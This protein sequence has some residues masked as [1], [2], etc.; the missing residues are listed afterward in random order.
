[1]VLHFMEAQLLKISP[2]CSGTVLPVTLPRAAGGRVHSEPI[3][4]LVFD[5]GKEL[6]VSD[7]VVSPISGRQAL[8]GLNQPGF[9]PFPLCSDYAVPRSPSQDYVIPRKMPSASTRASHQRETNYYPTP[10]L[11]DGVP[12]VI[13]ES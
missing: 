2:V 11:Q 4:Q 7:Q 1:M 12:T 9:A 3:L 8:V 5:P 6:L 10:S 13:L